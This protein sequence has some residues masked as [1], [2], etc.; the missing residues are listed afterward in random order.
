MSRR[1]Q[2]I[3]LALLTLLTGVLVLVALTGRRPAP[4]T[5]AAPAPRPSLSSSSADPTL[6]ATPSP[7]PTTAATPASPPAAALPEGLSGLRALVERD[8]AG[9]VL[10]F[11][12]GSGDEP[13]EWVRRW[14][15]DYLAGDRPL[16]YRAWN[17]DT[18]K[19]RRAD[20]DGG[21]GALTVWNASRRAPDLAGEPARVVKASRPADVVLLSYGHRK[22]ANEI[23]DALTAI[24]KAVRR[25]NPDATVIVLLQNPDPVQTQYLQQETVEEVRK[26]ARKADLDTVNIQDAFLNDPA[27]RSGLVE[28]DGSPTPT[29]SALWARTLQQATNA[30]R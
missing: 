12:D 10:V 29:G 23:G 25:R 28:A 2:I 6:Q 26:W 4:V 8:A 16:T 1:I 11:G 21:P 30:A 14:A 15:L 24:H 22:S 19:W 3:G 7:S 5:S 9:S 17:R 13:D 27:P 20:P 18:E